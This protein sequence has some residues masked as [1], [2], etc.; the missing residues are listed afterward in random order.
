MFFREV[1]PEGLARLVALLDGVG[2]SRLSCAHRCFNKKVMHAAVVEASSVLG[3]FVPSTLKPPHTCWPQWH[4]ADDDPFDTFIS[5]DPFGALCGKVYRLFGSSPDFKGLHRELSCGLSLV[6]WPDR[7]GTLGVYKEQSDGSTKVGSVSCRLQEDDEIRSA[8]RGGVLLTQIGEPTRLEVL[9]EF[10][11]CAF[12]WE[13]ERPDGTYVE[14][15]HIA[16]ALTEAGRKF[17]FEDCP[18]PQVTKGG[19]VLLNTP[20]CDWLGHHLLR[21][22]DAAPA[23]TAIESEATFWGT[24]FAEQAAARKERLRG[25]ARAALGS[26]VT[27][28]S[29]FSSIDETEV[30]LEPGDVGV[31]EQ[32]DADGDALIIFDRHGEVWVESVDFPK[33]RRDTG[34]HVVSL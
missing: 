10:D 7:S 18:G 28:T 13:V 16:L 15:M 12:E 20:N 8:I 17:R 27:V 26:K 23:A 29:A 33:L 1:S 9:K 32:L 22:T 3:R 19:D 6:L 2:M 14:Q 25:A 24:F 31:P 5:E 21:P 34:T 4:N 11:P 30:R